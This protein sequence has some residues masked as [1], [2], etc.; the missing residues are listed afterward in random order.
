LDFEGSFCI[1]GKNRTVKNLPLIL[2]PFLFITTTQ[3][4]SQKFPT[5]GEIYDFNPGDE[6]HIAHYYCCNELSFQ[7]EQLFITDAFVEQGQIYYAIQRSVFDFLTTSPPLLVD[8]TLYLHPDT[9]VIKHPD[10]VIFN[11]DDSMFTDPE[12]YNGRRVFTHTYW[13]LNSLKEERYVMGCGQVF[14]GW[15]LVPGSTCDVVDSLLYY[16]KGT[17][18]WGATLSGYWQQKTNDSFVIGPNPVHEN[19]YVKAQQSGTKIMEMGILDMQGRL[20]WKI[21]P[22][23]QSSVFEVYMDSKKFEGG[24]YFLY[25]RTEN[26]TVHYKFIKD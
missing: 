19:L 2:V 1:F 3:G 15:Q 4:W 12:A 16:K 17:E 7:V 6:F 11:P 9:L 25:I 18:S 20:T 5:Q 10:T 26:G 14:N 24:V 13:V 8:T 21:A 23:A 22:S